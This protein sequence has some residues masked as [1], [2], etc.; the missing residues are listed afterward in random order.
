M[1]ED[2]CTEL[3]S[4]VFEEH[5]LDSE[6]QLGLYQDEGVNIWSTYGMESNHA[7]IRWP[8]QIK[9][10]LERPYKV[11]EVVSLLWSDILHLRTTEK[12]ESFTLNARALQ[13]HRSVG[14]KYI[15][16]TNILQGHWSLETSPDGNFL[17]G[18]T[19]GQSR[20]WEERVM[21]I[22][23]KLGS[24]YISGFLICKISA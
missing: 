9:H 16:T 10:S 14:H 4:V 19:A 11:A 5:L 7:S 23:Q 20:V 24:C 3:I 1:M 13:K 21:L 12:M 6:W 8:R 15:T 18:I 22:S 17:Q 2:L